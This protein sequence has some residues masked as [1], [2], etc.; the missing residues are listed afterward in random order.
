MSLDRTVTEEVIL[1]ITPEEVILQITPEE[2]LSPR[3]HLVAGTD[4]GETSPLV[5]RRRKAGEET[6]HYPT[7]S[8]Q[9]RAESH[10]HSYFIS[11]DIVS[12]TNEIVLFVMLLDDLC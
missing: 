12:L 3:H 2:D 8:L 5:T 9:L 6:H 11:D 4:A 7:G 10:H 1:Q